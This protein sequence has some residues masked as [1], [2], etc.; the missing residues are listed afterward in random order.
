[1]RSVI[2]SAFLSSL[3]L[4]QHLI[5]NGIFRERFAEGGVQPL[6]QIRDRFIVAAHQGDTHF[7]T[8]RRQGRATYRWYLTDRD[9][10]AGVIEEG[11]DVFEG[12]DGGK[13]LFHHAANAVVTCVG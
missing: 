10:T 12:R 13:G 11:L 5:D 3:D 6:E 2:R 8:L 9:L 4:G 1:M 7:L